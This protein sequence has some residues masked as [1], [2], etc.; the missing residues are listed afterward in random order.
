MK[1]YTPFIVIGI[2]LFILLLNYCQPA[3]IKYEIR[4]N[5]DSLKREIR[6]DLVQREVKVI[7]AVKTDSVRIKYITRWKEIRH[8]SVIPCQEKL[9]ACDTI[10]K[11]D[12]T[13][14]AQLKEVIK[15][16]SNII[17]NQQ[18]VIH[19]DSVQITG[20]KKEVKKQ[21]RHKMFLAAL[22]SILAAVAIA[23]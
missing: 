16:D 22:T 12:S 5:T 19:Q 17:F 10:I 18:K 13:E 2:L 15:I 4:I 1:K 9:K 8:D 3:P 11:I 23:R 21:K 7:E 20:L 6:K 14:I